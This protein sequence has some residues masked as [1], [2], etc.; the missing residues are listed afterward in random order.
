MIVKEGH[1]IMIKESI[2][3]GDIILVNIYVPNKG[4]PKYIKQ[5]LMVINGEIDNNTINLRNFNT[6]LHQW[7][8]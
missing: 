5:M 6:H 8:D 3:E 2:Q 7:I 4:A 1:Y